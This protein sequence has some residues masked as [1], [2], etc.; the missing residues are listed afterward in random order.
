MTQKTVNRK[1]LDGKYEIYG[2][3]GEGGQGVVYRARD[4]HME[5]FVAI[6]TGKCV[7]SAAERQLLRE[8]MEILKRLRHPMLPAVYDYFE[9]DRQYLV[10]EYIEGISLHN[11]IE[12]EGCI[13]E[14][15]ACEWAIQLLDLLS[16][17][18][19]QKPSVIYRD[20]KPENIM[21]CPEGSLR[22]VDF[23]AA[24]SPCYRKTGQ[25][26]VAGTIGY[27]APEQLTDG[28]NGAGRADER[29]DIYT[30]G[31]TLYHML[32]GYNP[33]LPPCGIRPVR[34]M[35][36]NLTRRIERIVGKCTQA[37]PSK[38]YQTVEEIREDLL[39]KKRGHFSP[40]RKERRSQ[41]VICKM[42]KR[43]WLTEKKTVG[44]FVLG[45]LLGTALLYGAALSVCGREKPLP[46]TV[47]NKQGQKLVIRY[48][49]IYTADGDFVF[50][51]EKKLFDRGGRQEL[52][53]SLTD[54]ETGKRRERIFSIE[55]GG[56]EG[57]EKGN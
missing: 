51:L 57:E 15:K 22:V 42:E 6:K 37:E 33:S 38:R 49:S 47:Y 41:F 50:E 43:I 40:G 16:Y 26:T 25:E 46:V 53:I 18:H 12:L 30:F 56:C 8:E 19:G 4:K 55:G 23:G 36:P 24:L 45:G 52:S 27:A 35:A 3:I 31:A 2:Q 29:S 9:E 34:C 7:Q 21:V 28:R 10:M 20:L 32:T 17:L 44:L 11:F 48:D 54:C 14:K 1:V 13:P 39:C 5:R